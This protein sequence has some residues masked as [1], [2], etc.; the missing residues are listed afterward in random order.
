MQISTLSL[1]QLLSLNLS[2]DRLTWDEAS[3]CA[4]SIPL[5]QFQWSSPSPVL[6]L[7][8]VSQLSLATSLQFKEE[9]EEMETV[10]SQVS[11]SNLRLEFTVEPEEEEEEEEEEREEEN[12]CAFFVGSRVFK[13]SQVSA[14][15]M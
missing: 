13:H 1:N 10:Y 12:I 6:S 15:T 11:L 2:T 5:V 3:L 14:T 7:G 8:N 4:M 9:E